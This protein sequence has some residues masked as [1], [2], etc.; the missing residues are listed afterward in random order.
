MCLAVQDA[1]GVRMIPQGSHSTTNLKLEPP[2]S[3]K[4]VLFGFSLLLF[5]CTMAR[6]LIGHNF[7]NPDE[8]PD[9]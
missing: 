1:S 5:Y 4:D 7:E 6:I 3:E 9:F 2:K 8:N